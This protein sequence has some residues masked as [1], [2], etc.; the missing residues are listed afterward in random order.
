MS[1]K[2]SMRTPLARI[3]YLGSAH[4]GTDHFWKQRV[5]AVALIPLTIAF[6]LIIISLVGRNQAA[7]IQIIGSPF[8]AIT[9]LLFVLSGVHH[10]WLGM[11]VIIE[12]YVHSEDWKLTC[13]MANTFFSFAIAITCIF[14]VL[15]VAFGV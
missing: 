3:R 7:A 14:A 1:G 4:A 11:Q 8:V 12:D 13:L 10:M 15:K 9:M 5:T 6:V 2:S